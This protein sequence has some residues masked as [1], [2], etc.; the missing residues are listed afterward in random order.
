[1]KLC[2]EKLTS[3]VYSSFINETAGTGMNSFEIRVY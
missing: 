2:Q 3:E 1:M